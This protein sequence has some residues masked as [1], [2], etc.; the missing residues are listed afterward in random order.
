MRPMVLGA[1]AL[2]LRTVAAIVA[3]LCVGWISSARA[4]SVTDWNEVAVRYVGGGAG[5]PAGRPGPVGFLDVALVQAAVHDAV[6]AIEGRYAPYHYTGTGAGSKNAAVAAAAHRTLVQLYPSQQASL[7][8]LYN[9][10]LTTH[11]LVA[12]P[13]LAVGEASAASVFTQY[14]PLVVT[15]PFFGGTQ[16]GQWRPV[17][18]GPP[19]Q[20]LT[21]AFTEPFTLNRVTQFRPEPPPPL[22]S[23]KYVR[24]YNEVKALGSLANYPNANTAL[25][26]FW[27][28]DPLIRWN[29]G[30]RG[31][32][33]NKDVGESAR[34][35]ALANLAA[36]DTLMGIFEAKYF[37]NFW[38]PSTA[39]TNDDGNPKTAIDGGWKAYLP[40]PPYPDYPSGMNGVS[41]AMTETMR[42]FFGTD[43]VSFSMN[44]GAVVR[45]YSS[46]SQA[47]AEVIEVRILQGI[48]VRSA[49]V[50]GRQQGERTAHWAF[51]HILGTDKGHDEGVATEWVVDD[52]KK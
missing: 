12:N 5:I 23:M 3:C 22:T 31:L 36:A 20:F 30:I 21:L 50:D 10:Y 29:G 44:Q 11:G 2:R 39:I 28:G 17:A 6:Q 45:N 1:S 8:T 19:M 38:R 7:D 14:R 43:D 37:Y 9:T 13:G 46:F 42:L 52:E 27:N 15:T 25:V 40:N 16:P 26:D 49:E 35:F 34:L 32:M 51:H 47:A 18:N 4:N 48:H 24:E 33:A 41:G